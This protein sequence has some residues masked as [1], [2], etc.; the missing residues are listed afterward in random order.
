MEKLLKLNVYLEERPIFLRIKTLE[1]EVFP[2]DSLLP[3]IPEEEMM[4]KKRRIKE[5]R[6]LGTF[7]ISN[8]RIAISIN[9]EGKVINV[10]EKEGSFIRIGKATAR[11]FPEWKILEI[12]DCYL[13]EE[14][15]FETRKKIIEEFENVLM[16]ELSPGPEK[17][18]LH[19]EEPAYPE[20]SYK[21]LWNGVEVGEYLLKVL[22]EFKKEK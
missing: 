8:L 9:A 2:Y 13:W 1:E 12:W 17:I 11:Y 5:V 15:K 21:P 7:L 4:K 14:A 22:K 10:E 6:I 3:D 20:G 16:Q 18:Y 19:K